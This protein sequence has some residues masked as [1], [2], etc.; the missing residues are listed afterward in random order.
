MIALPCSSA[1]VRGVLGEEGADFF[2]IARLQ[3][4]FKFCKLFFAQF[5]AHLPHPHVHVNALDLYQQSLNLIEPIGDVHGKAA[6]LAMMAQLLA[7][8]QGDFD[9]ALAYLQE[10]IAIL[11]HLQSPDVETV[12]RIAFRVWMRQM[13]EKLGEEKFAELETLLQS[14][15]EEKI[16]AFLAEHAPDAG[17]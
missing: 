2:L 17:G 6:T 11:T 8:E 13:R 1:G 7:D 10:S 3:H 9:T 12:K 15:D 14:G 4:R 16:R 5:F